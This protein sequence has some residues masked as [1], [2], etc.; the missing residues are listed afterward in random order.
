MKIKDIQLKYDIDKQKKIVMNRLATIKTNKTVS[1]KEEIESGK[2]KKMN[3]DMR[4]K[5]I[6]EISENIENICL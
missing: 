4:M 1:K 6:K 5:A 2:I 3:L